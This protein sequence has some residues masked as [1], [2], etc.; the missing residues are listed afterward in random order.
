[1]S[2]QIVVWKNRV[3]IITVE[4]GF[5]ISNEEWTSQIR[6]EPKADAPL[7]AEWSVAFENDGTD[8]RLLLTLTDVV[9]AQ[10][11]ADSG[12]M[13][14]RRKVAFGYPVAAIDKPLEVIFRGSVTT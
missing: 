8:G 13:D 7:L 9:T 14:F 12:F 11:T 10:I 6:S 2:D 5:D 1:M 3:N 4:V